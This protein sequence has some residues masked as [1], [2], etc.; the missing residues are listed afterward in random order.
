MAVFTLLMS[1]LHGH[2]WVYLLS[3]MATITS[4]LFIRFVKSYNAAR[5][6]FPGPP[7]RNFFVGNL[8]QMMGDDVH[9]KVGAGT[10]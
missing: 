1:V 5:N 4:T 2:G 6:Q 8:D 9:E 7:V 3:V 10:C